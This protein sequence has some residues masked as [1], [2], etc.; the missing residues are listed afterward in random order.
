MLDV[1]RHLICVLYV[2]MALKGSKE[3]RLHWNAIVVGE[4]T[5][6]SAEDGIKAEA[7][8]RPYPPTCV[9]SKYRRERVKTASR[10]VQIYRDLLLKSPTVLMG[11]QF[12]FKTMKDAGIGILDK[13]TKRRTRRRVGEKKLC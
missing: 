2:E 4:T 5:A 3:E 13:W 7:G 6:V 12:L 10:L 11:P 9:L 8:W 1:K